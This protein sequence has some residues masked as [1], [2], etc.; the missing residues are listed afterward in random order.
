MEQPTYM[1]INTHKTHHFLGSFLSVHESLGDDTRC[2]KLIALTEL[3][4]ED[5]VGEAES[6][7]PDTLQDTVAAQ[8]VQN[9]WGHD[10]S[11]LSG[12]VWYSLEMY[13]T[14]ILLI[15]IMHLVISTQFLR[16]LLA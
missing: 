11:S 8:L 4:E 13:T 10:L 6:A 2:E 12:N 16:L 3:L 9:E 7:D 15:A 5:S 14:R 1:Y